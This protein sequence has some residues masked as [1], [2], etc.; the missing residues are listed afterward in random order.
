MRSIPLN[1][2]AVD[3]E[4]SDKPSVLKRIGVLVP[5]MVILGLTLPIIVYVGLMQFSGWSAPMVG[6][7]AAFSSVTGA[8]SRILLYA[9]PGTKSY[10][11]GIG[12]NYDTLLV[13]WRSY[14]STRK[15]SV[16]EIEETKPLQS[17]KDG[18]LILPSAVSLNADER[19]DILA[20][21]D[22]GGSILTTWA[23]GSRNANGTWEGWQFLDALGVKM[24]GEIPAAAE[25]N[26]L[27]LTGES[28]VSNTLLSGQRVW[29]SKTT[30]A[31][32]RFEGQRIA[33]RFM[34]WGR[35]VDDERRTEG[36][37]VY[38]ESTARSARAVS[39]AFAETA[40]ESHPLDIYDL[41][42][43]SIRWLSHEPV[44]VRAAWPKGIRASQLIEMDTE[45]GFANA[46]TFASMMQALD[47]R[48]TFYVLTSVAKGF[49]EILAR[50]ARDFEVG[51]HADVHVGFKGQPGDV[52][53][54]RI[55]GMQA[56]LD[57]LLMDS[58]G[59][60]GFRAPTE[61]YDETTE[62][63]LQKHGIRHH[64][65]DPGRSNSR[66]PLIA[67]LEDESDKDVLVVLPRTQRDDINLYK[68]NLTPEQTTKA[69]I[70]DFDL[71]AD[72]G[73][74]GVLSVHSQN[75]G[76]NSALVQAM[77][78]FLAHV[79]QH[80]DLVWMASA[81]QIAD[82]WRGR[83]RVKLNARYSG[84]RLDVDVSVIGQ[85]PVFDSALVVMLPQ[86]GVSVIVQSVKVGQP[87]PVVSR[88]D[89]FRS[90]V[91]FSKLKP[92]NYAYQV[93]FSNP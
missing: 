46:L 67:K 6:V 90:A 30:E 28:P 81:S 78:G 11:A 19:S 88:I 76:E 79:K 64:T 50:L 23:T 72:I 43:D 59:I 17:L 8:S 2:A 63:L 42:D 49:P 7:N 45:E 37:I 75:F 1:D 14:F 48:A 9:S 32:L 89:D 93:T 4:I 52:Q 39:Y 36:A 29:M 38:S 22:R 34:N 41:L 57:A 16:T 56:D 53:E 68:E 47:Y 40:W 33:G 66:L 27:V 69:L 71:T 85:D 87:S 35:V 5:L 25:V 10:F 92:G 15:W 84:K 62:L 77:P 24:V 60:T 82:W 31:L 73:S 20:F 86:K 70:D 65:A 80:R 26:H 58:K 54:K 55:L 44:A 91:T 18:V 12:G 21:R 3:G 83:E 51:Y 74:L 13:P 61:S